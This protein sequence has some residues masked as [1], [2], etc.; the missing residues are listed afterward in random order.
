MII[1]TVSKLTFAIMQVAL[2]NWHFMD[3]F[4]STA[5]FS[6][7]LYYWNLINSFQEMIIIF[8]QQLGKVNSK[9]QQNSKLLIMIMLFHMIMPGRSFAQH[10]FQ[11]YQPYQVCVLHF[12]SHFLKKYLSLLKT[13]MNDRREYLGNNKM[14]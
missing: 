3:N 9:F 6:H 12:F 8:G 5:I 2:S 11:W 1:I 10:K 13:A 14:I 4:T 7:L